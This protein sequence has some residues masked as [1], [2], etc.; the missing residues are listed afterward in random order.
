MI[1]VFKWQTASPVPNLAETLRYMGVRGE[2]TPELIALAEKGIEKV[3]AAAVC[4]G[5]YARVP[6]EVPDDRRVIIAGE[7]VITGSLAKHLHGC[8]EAY[9]TA[10]T[11]GIGIDR[12]IRTTAAVSQAE[13][14]AID[15]AGSSAAEWVCDELNEELGQTASREGKAL[16]R[17]FSP[18][19]GDFPLEY[20]RSFMRLLDL[21]K[22]AGITLNDSLLMSPTKSV[23]AVIGIE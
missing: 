14:L 17:R 12:L 11:V 16:R 5:C 7:T 6:I 4:R 1:Q 22:N 2:P 9:L 20:Q 10:A 15:A 13:C 19:Y 8:G 18:G 21:S 23:T 3:R